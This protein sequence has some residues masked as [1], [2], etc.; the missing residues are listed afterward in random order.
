M[1]RSQNTKKINEAVSYLKK[2]VKEGHI[3]QEEHDI[4]WK[5]INSKKVKNGQIAPSTIKSNFVHLCGWRRFYSINKEYTECSYDDLEMAISLIDM[6]VSDT[7]GDYLSQNTIRDYILDLK[8][9][10]NFLIERNYSTIEKKMMKDINPPRK[11]R[12]TKKLENIPTQKMIKSMIDCATSIRDK[13]F[14]YV[15]YEGGFRLCEI[16]NM[17]WNQITFDNDGGV[18]IHVCEKTGYPR[19]VPLYASVRYL[20]MLKDSYPIDVNGD[21]YVFLSRYNQQL[22]DETIRKQFK[23]IVKKAGYSTK[24]TPHYFR[25]A[26]ITHLIRMGMLECDIKEIMWGNQNTKEFLTYLHIS[27][28]TLKKSVRKASKIESLDDN[29]FYQDYVLEAK[30][31]S[32]CGHINSGNSKI[33]ENPNCNNPLEVY[34]HNHLKQFTQIIENVSESELVMSILQKMALEFNLDSIPSEV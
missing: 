23:L 19:Y 21:S 3:T 15:M 11:N 32:L 2:Q 5:F 6:T 7:T 25:H 34:S 20:K 18:T 16:R 13:A 10:F 9:F 12:H 28:V 22:K 27:G 14:L 17:K 26:R 8:A 31:C 33:C 1:T 30:K 4:F 29:D 24:I